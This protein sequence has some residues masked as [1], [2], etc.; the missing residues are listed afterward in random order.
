MDN[1]R[2]CVPPVMVN[3]RPATFR[4]FAAIGGLWNMS[5]CECSIELEQDYPFD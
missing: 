4:E 2:P 5:K 3:T 1:P